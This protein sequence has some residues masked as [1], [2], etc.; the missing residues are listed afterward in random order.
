MYKSVEY[1][2]FENAAL[3][4]SLINELV[5]QWVDGFEL[6]SIRLESQSV[7]TINCDI[8]S[9]T[10]KEYQSIELRNTWNTYN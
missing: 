6:D 5:P 4:K 7:Y 3:V 9:N 2:E 8:H 1:D 10:D